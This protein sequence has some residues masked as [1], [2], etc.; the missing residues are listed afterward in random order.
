MSEGRERTPEASAMTEWSPRQRF[1]PSTSRIRRTVTHETTAL[2]Q[3][4]LSSADN[5]ARAVQG[6]SLRPLACCQCGFECCREQECLSLVN[7]VC[8]QIEVSG[9]G[10]SLVQRSPTI[11]GVSVC[12]GKIS[13]MRVGTR[14]SCATRG[15]GRQCICKRNT[16]ACSCNHCCT[17]EAILSVFVAL[18]I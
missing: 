3:L 12:G 4:L 1:K 11:C 7:V 16:E 14:G 13:I 6:V 15:G 10:W 18:V 2:S 5:G 17:G 8:C 9:S